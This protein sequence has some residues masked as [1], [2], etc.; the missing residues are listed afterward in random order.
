[1]VWSEEF[2]D[3]LQNTVGGGKPKMRWYFSPERNGWPANSITGVAPQTEEDQT[4]LIDALQVFNSQ[5]AGIQNSAVDHH[6]SPP[7]MFKRHCLAT[8]LSTSAACHCVKLNFRCL[9]KHTI[10]KI[11]PKTSHVLPSLDQ[12]DFFIACIPSGAWSIRSQRQL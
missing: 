8:A 4:R 7:G 5:C 9:R 11:D 6:P 3:E 2:Y 10:R 1:M 12:N